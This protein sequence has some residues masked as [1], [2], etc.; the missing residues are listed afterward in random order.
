[1]RRRRP[2]G[3]ERGVRVH[4]ER[5]AG[6]EVYVNDGLVRFS[7]LGL[8][9]GVVERPAGVS[10]HPPLPLSPADRQ[11]L[12]EACDGVELS[13]HQARCLALQAENE[14]RKTAFE[15]RVAQAIE[16]ARS[17]HGRWPSVREVQERLRRRGLPAGRKE[18]IAAGLRVARSR[19]ADDQAQ[20]RG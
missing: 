3:P 5:M 12:K 15:E 19:D 4:C 14:R 17:L 9:I 20:R 1:M 13:P 11:V 7:D 10:H 6:R 16:S 18:K 8:A 2:E